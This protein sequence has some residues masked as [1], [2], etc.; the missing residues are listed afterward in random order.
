[1]P[2][3]H[4]IKAD[5]AAVA[6]ENNVEEGSEKNEEEG[7]SVVSSPNGNNNNVDG[8]G[9]DAKD[10]D[11]GNEEEEEAVVNA[12]KDSKEPQLV[13]LPPKEDEDGA[14]KGKFFLYIYLTY[15]CIICCGGIRM[16]YNI[17]VGD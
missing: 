4:D 7:S 14:K 11:D 16:S 9:E 13:N 6:E 12:Q 2:T 15:T 17:C 1:M 5:E 3:K 10:Y 8:K